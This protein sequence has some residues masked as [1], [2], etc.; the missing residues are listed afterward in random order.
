V[1]GVDGTLNLTWTKQ[2]VSAT[3]DEGINE[4]LISCST[5]QFRFDSITIVVEKV[6]A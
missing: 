1:T 3:Y 5:G 6:S 2:N 4:V